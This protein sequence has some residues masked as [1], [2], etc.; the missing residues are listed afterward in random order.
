[1]VLFAESWYPSTF[2]FDRIKSMFLRITCSGFVVSG[3]RAFD[4]FSRR[5]EIPEKK[6]QTGYSV[7][8][9]DHF[10]VDRKSGAFKRRVLCIARFAPEKNIALLIQAF[11]DSKLSTQGW[12]LWL[13]GG[14]GLESSLRIHASDAPISILPWRSYEELPFIYAEAG[15]FVL[16]SSFEPWGLVVNE[17]MS[18]GL[19]LVLSD[20]VGCLPDLLYPGKNGWSF[21]THDTADLTRV[22]DD[23]SMTSEQDL[24]VMGLYSQSIVQDFSLDTFAKGVINLTQ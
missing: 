16:P 2:I 14:G 12:E 21:K 13:V 23:V 5:L 1:V 6:I 9:N 3:K 11:I 8:D 19:P 10:K 17:A 22:L 15:L 24:K 18:A 20:S 4:H 7:V